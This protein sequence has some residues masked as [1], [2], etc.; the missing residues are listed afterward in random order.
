MNV[1]KARLN[2][3]G[4]EMSNCITKAAVAIGL[5]TSWGWA[6]SIAAAAPIALQNATATHQSGSFPQ[7]QAIDGTTTGSNGWAPGSTNVDANPLIVFETVSDAGPGTYSFTFRHNVSTIPEHTLARFRLSATTDDRND[8]ADGIVGGDVTANWTV[9]TPTSAV[10]TVP[11][12]ATF[13]IVGDEVQV[14]GTSPVVDTYEVTASVLLDDITGF[15]IETISSSTAPT[16]PG[17]ASNRNFILSEFEVDAA[18]FAGAIPEPSSMALLGVGLVGWTRRRRRRKQ[19]GMT[20][21]RMVLTADSMA[22]NRL[23]S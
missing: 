8:F 14:S 21:R 6:A 5:L 2:L 4:G 10:S 20:S 1:V 11:S 7:A 13:A 19:V 15:R 12:G 17:R 18:A 16:G 22:G 3:S 9:L 23:T